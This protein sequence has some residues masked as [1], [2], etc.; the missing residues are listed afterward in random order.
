MRKLLCKVAAE[1]YE[2]N[3][4]LSNTF[5]HSDRNKIF[6]V[7]Y[8]KLYCKYQLLVQNKYCNYKFDK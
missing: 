2:N 6:T 7:S 5:L 4:Y 3:R 1:F 8:D